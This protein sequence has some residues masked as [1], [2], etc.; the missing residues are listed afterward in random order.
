[1]RYIPPKT[2]RRIYA[3]VLIV[4][5]IVILLGA[6]LRSAA[7]MYTAAPV[8]LADLVFYFIWYRCPHCGRHLGRAWGAYCPYCGIEV[9]K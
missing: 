8:M 3:A 1:M 6:A 7:M 5:T 4:C 9:V 2:V